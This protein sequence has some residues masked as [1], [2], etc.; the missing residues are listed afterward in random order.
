[1]RW[2]ENFSVVEPEGSNT[3]GLGGPQLDQIF[4]ILDAGL[5]RTNG[6]RAADVE[7]NSPWLELIGSISTSPPG[8]SGR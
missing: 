6:T 7:E 4:S 1:M 2:V 5:V 3:V 8:N